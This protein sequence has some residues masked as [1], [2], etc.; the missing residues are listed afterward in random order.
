MDTQPIAHY[1]VLGHPIAHSKSPQIHHLFAQQ[2]GR[3]L[4]YKAILVPI[5]DFTLTIQTLFSQHYQGLNVTVPFKFEAFTA[6]VSRTERAERAGA[7]NTLLR[8]PEGWQGDN[9]D[10]IGL[11]N[12][13]RRL[14]S[15]LSGELG[16]N[17]LQGKRV[18][19]LGAGGA[20]SGVI[21]PLLA[22]GIDQLTIANR[23]ADKAQQ[24]AESAQHLR[25]N[26]C[27]YDVVPAQEYDIIINATSASLAGE[28]PPLKPEWFENAL[29]YDMM[30]GSQPT[31]FLQTA[32][33]YG[34]STCA[35]GLGMLV[36]QAAEAF[37][38]WQGIRPET[39]PVLALLRAQLTAPKE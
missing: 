7:V 10:G 39:L 8:T 32:A 27:G 35:D 6:C 12:D 9:T 22:E 37:Y 28:L 21:H 20:S 23:T 5:N 31:I 25:I 30:Y 19:L 29:A 15:D 13:L 18:L 4:D 24:L 1:A 26:G 34:A 3:Y 17:G 33:K 14:S 11:V 38:L 2:T 16:G 36:E